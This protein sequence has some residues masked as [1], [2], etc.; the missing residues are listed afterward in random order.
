MTVQTLLQLPLVDFG[1]F[2]HGK[3]D[4]R[5]RAAKQLV[6][7]FRKH[8]FVRLKNHGV[9]KEFVQEI[10]KWVFMFIFFPLP[11]YLSLV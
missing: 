6:D 2:L 3:P 4:E 1:L 11:F 7:S 5:K 10:W 8:G 9:S